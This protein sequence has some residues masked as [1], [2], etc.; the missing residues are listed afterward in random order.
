MEHLENQWLDTLPDKPFDEAR[1]W[2][3]AGSAG[4]GKSRAI[5]DTINK[6]IE[7]GEHPSS[8]CYVLFNREPA[9]KFREYYTHK[10][11][12]DED[13]RHWGTHHSLMRRLLKVPIGKILSDKR[14]VAWGKDHG[15]EFSDGFGTK[16]KT[17]WDN[18]FS[19]LSMKLYTART[20]FNP[21]E[22]R[23]LVALNESETKDK[24][25]THVRY[26]C[27]GCR[28]GLYPEGIK[29]YFMDEAQDNGRVQM[30]W[31][32]GIIAKPEVKG[33]MLAGDDKQ[34]INQFKGSDPYLF[35]DFPV[36]RKVSLKKT[37]R[38]PLNILQEANRIVQP[39]KKRS[40]LADLSDKDVKGK[41][42]HGSNFDSVANA[43]REELKSGHDVLALV[44]DN[45]VKSKLIAK[46]FDFGLIVAGERMVR[47][48]QTIKALMRVKATGRM[49]DIDMMLILPDG[50]KDGCLKQTAYWSKGVPELI[51][52]GDFRHDPTM[53]EAY[54]VMRLGQGLPLA[55]LGLMGFLPSFAED[56]STWN[57][58]F[59]NWRMSRPVLMAYKAMVKDASNGFGTMRVS[60]IHSVK[61]M[62]EDNVLVCTDISRQTRRAE[63]E[64]PDVERRVWYVALT[65]SKN[66]LFIAQIDP[67]NM[68]TEFV[69]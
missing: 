23:L 69:W 62:E 15:F 9:D 63:M 46:A 56:V 24:Q 11:Y 67:R 50:N 55:D 33:L 37:Y 68:R 5:R 14:L 36:D 28:M 13:L 31:L 19:S 35:L 54:D 16:G 39:I 38:C 32:K 18:V 48:S 49:T 6:L 65:R 12:T 60:T 45:F 42:I 43:I 44:R 7:S 57:I 3:V 2:L 61:G 41:I 4:S 40:P 10:G 34:A 51:A 52:S 59:E 66:N 30:D 20:D 25:W 64:T 1:V 22:Y 29:Y 8:I 47:L 58:P 27:A 26:L 17:E 53:L 21:L